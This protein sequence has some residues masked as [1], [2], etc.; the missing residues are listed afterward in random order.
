MHLVMHLTM[1]LGCVFDSDY[2]L[3]GHA[4]RLRLDWHVVEEN[5]HLYTSFT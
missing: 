2:R 1:I 3:A 4:G 5:S